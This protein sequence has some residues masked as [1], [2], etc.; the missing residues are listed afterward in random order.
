MAKKRLIYDVKQKVKGT[1]ATGEANSFQLFGSL[2]D[3]FVSKDPDGIYDL[4][5]G[6]DNTFEMV[7]VVNQ[8]FFGPSHGHDIFLESKPVLAL[9]GTHIG[10]TLKQTLLVATTKDGNNNIA[11]LAFAIV[12]SESKDSWLYFCQKLKEAIPETD[13]NIAIISDRD[14]GLQSALPEV[15]PSACYGHCCFHL[16]QNLSKKKGKN[17]SE[18]VPIFWK[19]CRT[20]SRVEMRKLMQ[21]LKEY[22]Q[23]AYDYLKD[24]DPRSYANSYFPIPRFGHLTSNMSESINGAW[25]NFRHLPVFSVV[26]N[27]WKWLV[28]QQLTRS[29]LHFA[30]NLTNDAQRKL[31]KN[32]AASADYI[33]EKR[34]ET[35][36]VIKTSGSEYQVDP[37]R[38]LCSCEEFQEL[39]FP[40][41]HAVAS[42]QSRDLD[43]SDFVHPSY[44]A[45]RHRDSYF[46]DLPV[47][48]FKN[49]K[50]SNPNPR[51]INA[52]GPK[53][54]AGRPKN[55]R[56]RTDR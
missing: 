21:D 42:L 26:E 35:V 54:S 40:C 8:A 39:Q 34:T 27:I 5:V 52:P 11:V 53:K 56:I 51:L 38:R 2:V 50:E 17:K 6:S 20:F 4:R 3:E 33:V 49:I 29:G 9:D 45:E 55:K 30:T 41:R 15:F 28:S 31:E 1:G 44:L 18:V 16:S 23:A 25:K 7:R 37:F 46:L 10:S 24:I 47:L 14:K 13:A 36:D 12:Q 19:I 22:D 32:I 48:L 43:Y